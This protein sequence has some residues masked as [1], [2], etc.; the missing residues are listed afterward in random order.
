MKVESIIAAVVA[1]LGTTLFTLLLYLER[2]GETSYMILLVTLGLISLALHGFSRLHELDLKQLRIT[3]D[4]IEKVKS[5]IEE[6]YGGIDHI[7]RS[8]YAMTPEK[9]SYL[10]RGEGLVAPGAEMRYV[11]GVLI[12]ERERLAR[13]FVNE[14]TPEKIAEA[15]LDSSLNDNVFKWSGPESPLDAPTKGTK[16]K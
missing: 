11:A 4:R 1:I 9:L 5:E 2:M 13:I 6:M 8:A 7:R 3:L 15:I 12:R 14:K 10:G 16:D